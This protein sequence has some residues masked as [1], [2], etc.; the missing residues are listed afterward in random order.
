MH[1]LPFVLDTFGALAPR[2]SSFLRE[3]ARGLQR[4]V[5]LTNPQAL[6]RVRLRLLNV[7]QVHVSNLLLVGRPQL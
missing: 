4:S 1:L 2:A 6:R 7:V 5:G 3:V